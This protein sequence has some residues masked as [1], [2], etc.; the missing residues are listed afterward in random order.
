MKKII[1]ILTF[2]IFAAA[3]LVAQKTPVVGT[4]DVQ[5]VLSDYNEFQS[6]VEKVR[7]SVAPV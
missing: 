7:G 6:A 3:G 5:R 1:T 2:S 4:V